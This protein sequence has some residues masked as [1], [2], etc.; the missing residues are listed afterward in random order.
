MQWRIIA[1]A[2][3]KK[4]AISINRGKCDK[5]LVKKHSMLRSRGIKNSTSRNGLT[6]ICLYHQYEEVQLDFISN[7]KSRPFLELN[8][9]SLEQYSVNYCY[10]TMRN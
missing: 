1:T 3:Q 2:S 7:C 6:S 4:I 8:I 10:N 9:R 5:M